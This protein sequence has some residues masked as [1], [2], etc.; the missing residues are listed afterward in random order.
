S[1]DSSATSRGFQFRLNNAGQLELNLIAAGINPK[2]AIPSAGFHGYVSGNWYHVAATYDGTNIVMYW[3]LVDPSVT[4]ANPISTNAAWV[5]SGFGTV[6]GPLVIGN[7]NRGVAGENFQNLIDEVRISNIA[8]A[9][10]QML[11][12]SGGSSNSISATPT[13]I[14][15][16]NPVYAG[17]PVSLSA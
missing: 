3:T 9:A 17:T 4:A 14:V 13:V 16:P 8:R 6:Q 15:P 7:E 5:G 12:S 1:T 10:N 2:T 11:F